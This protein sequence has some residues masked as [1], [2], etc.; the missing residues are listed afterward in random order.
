MKIILISVSSLILLLNFF[1]II[2]QE[3]IYSDEQRIRG[4]LFVN[5][6]LLI[7]YLICI[8]LVL[9]IIFQIFKKN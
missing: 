7:N 1:W 3:G 5:P 4:G 9:F 2:I 8:P 6:N